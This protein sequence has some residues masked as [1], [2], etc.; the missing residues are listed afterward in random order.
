MFAEIHKCRVPFLPERH[1]V[2]GVL[3]GLES[4]DKT[5]EINTGLATLSTPVYER[6]L[7]QTPLRR[8]VFGDLHCAYNA[9]EVMGWLPIT[10]T[11]PAEVMAQEVYTRLLRITDALG[12]PQFVRIW[13]YIPN[14]NGDE[15]G[16][17]RYQAF[18]RGR[19]R[20]LKGQLERGYCSA[21][22]IG[23]QAPT[24]GARNHR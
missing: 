4:T 9:D 11:Q 24:G 2:V 13:H 16:E 22:V 23:T 21:T 1:L 19:R 3:S 15:N 5:S 17:S 18:C 8:D 10:A 7:S 12:F 6:W 14:L 20:I